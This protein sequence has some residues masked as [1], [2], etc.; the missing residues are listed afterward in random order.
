M[1]YPSTP[2]LPPNSTECSPSALHDPSVAA[3]CAD[4]G[5]P[6]SGNCICSAFLCYVNQGGGK[7]C[8]YTDLGANGAEVPTTSATGTTCCVYGDSSNGYI[9]SCYADQGACNGRGTTVSSCTAGVLP[10]CGGPIS[11]GS[12]QVSA[13]R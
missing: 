5:W 4:P 11:S 3:C 12:S 7:D 9:C 2:S 6:S 8:Y 13:C 1:C 10:A